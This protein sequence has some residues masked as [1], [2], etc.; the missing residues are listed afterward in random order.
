MPKFERSSLKSSFTSSSAKNNFKASLGK[1]KLQPF[2]SHY[3][4]KLSAVNNKLV[5]SL[6]A[7]SIC[8]VITDG[9]V[10]VA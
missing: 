5:C 9:D 4:T 8:D 7:R 6:S 1:S 3:V 2:G 10:R